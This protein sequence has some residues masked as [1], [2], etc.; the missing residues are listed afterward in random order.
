MSPS[1]FAVASEVNS[2]MA[3]G[4]KE[5]KDEEGSGADWFK[6]GAG[7]LTAVGAAVG[8]AVAGKMAYDYIKEETSDAPMEPEGEYGRN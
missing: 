7:I 8:A 6:I 3:S 1:L 2:E 5:K 4:G